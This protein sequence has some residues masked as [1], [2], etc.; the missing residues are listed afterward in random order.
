MTKIDIINRPEFQ[1]AVWD[2]VAKSIDACESAGAT[3]DEWYLENK[4]EKRLLDMPG[5]E[6]ARVDELVGYAEQKFAF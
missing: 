5:V 3:Y 4:W 6:N 1:N 2:C